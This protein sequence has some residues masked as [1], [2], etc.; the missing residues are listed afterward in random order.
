MKS[1]LGIDIGSVTISLV[2]VDSDKKILQSAYISHEGRLEEKLKNIL[3]LLDLSDIYGIAKTSSTPAIFK[4]TSSYD[5]RVCYITATKEINPE[6]GSLLIVGGEKFGLVLFDE[7]KEY[8]KYKS[9]SSCA[10]GTGSFL[11]QQAKRL[12]IETIEKFSTL[13]YQNHGAFPKIASRCAVFAKTDL[14]HAQ[15]EGYSLQEICDGLCFG[16]AK[17]IVD[18]LF[19]NL[20]CPEPLFFAGGVSQNQAVKKHIQNLIGIDVIT[21]EYGHLYG[22]IGAAFNLINENK[23]SEIIDFSN[24]DN[25]F[26][27][28]EKVKKYYY[29][30]LTLKLSKYPDFDSFKSYEFSSPVFE[31]LTPV[32]VDIYHEIN[33]KEYTIYLGID[34][35]STSTKAVII[36]NSKNV[37]AGFYTRTSG[38]PITAVQNIFSAI[39]DIIKKYD[40][41]FE[42]KGV[43]TTGSGRKFIGKIIGADIVLDEITAHARA[44]YE[45]DKDVDTIIE[46]GG[47]DAKFTTLSNGMVTFSIMNN[48]CAAGTGSFIEE[49]AKKLGVTLTEYSARAEKPSAPMASDRCTVFMERDLNHYLNDGYVVDEILASVLHSV[50][51]NYLTKV[52]IE[53]NIGNKIFFQG[54][55]A[56]N[57]ALVAAFEQRLNK[58]I[59]VSKYCHLTGALGVALDLFDKKHS[60]SKF[61][62]IDLFKIE[63]PIR[64]EICDICTNHCKLKIATINEITEAYGFLCGRDY[65][66]EKFVDNAQSNFNLVKEYN[67]VFRYKPKS[68]E[69]GNITIGIPSGLYL[70]DDI[71]LWRRFFEIL[72]FKTI[73]TEKF[74]NAVKEGKIIEGA[75]FCSPMAAIHG[76]VKYLIDKVDFVFLPTYL[77]DKQKNKEKRRQYCYYSQYIP[78]IISSIEEIEKKNKLINPLLY[79]V[80]SEFLMKIELFNSLKTAGLNGFNLVD[81]SNAYDTAKKEKSERKKK[82]KK[83]FAEVSES[84]ENKNNFKVILLGRPYT[85]LSSSMNN[86]IPEIFANHETLAFFQDQI[87]V[88]E[89]EVDSLQEILTSVKWKYAATILATADKIARTKDLYPVFI[90]SFKCTPDAFVIEYF[91]MIMAQ[92]KKPYLILQL[93]EHD[94]SVGYETRIEAAIRSFKNHYNKVDLAGI[95]KIEYTSS[96][97]ISN[98]NDLKG[99]T[100][101]LP[102]WDE[103]TSRLLEASLK[104]IGIDVRMIQ[105]TTDSIQR[106]VSSNTGQCL[107]LNIIIQDAI[108]YVEEHKLN[109]ENTVVWMLQSSVSCNLGMFMNFMSKTL[110]SY[111]ND[112]SKIRMYKG[113]LSFLD[114]SFNT[115]VNTYLSYM[116][117]G[118][119]RKIQCKIRPYEKQKGQ[120]DLIVKKSLDLLYDTFLTGG[121]KEIALQ[122]VISWFKEIEIEKTNRPKVAVFGDLYA[123]DND[124]FN[125]NL[126]KFIEDNGGEVITTPYSEY[127]KLILLPYNKRLIIEGAYATAAT[128]RFLMSLAPM[129]EGKYSKY[130]YEILNEE[131]MK[132]DKNFEDK[133]KLFNVKSAHNGESMDSILK[134][135]HLAQKHDDLALFV[136]TNPSYCCP[137]LVTEAMTTKLE[138]ITGIPIVTIEYDGTNSSKND[139]IIPFLKY[140]RKKNE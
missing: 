95:S 126:V 69:F 138:K 47:Q 56:K 27:N 129:V 1:Y 37:L 30:N 24:L 121:S 31:K 58:P 74:R 99:K 82:W 21:N 36:D 100:L 136:Q 108:D 70:F 7:D 9:N 48:V 33:K 38:Q 44:A 72:K 119:I 135:L 8:R 91:K 63:I 45:I 132:I 98:P 16:L 10:A 75:E 137:S 25:H 133:L 107:P 15:Q 42:I 77:E 55:T 96:N 118:Y 57:K 124:V 66:T 79:S 140:A 120:T 87:E 46:I 78:P 53:S 28:H 106:S 43:S 4:N 111:N 104:N 14:I 62:G 68:E 12:N 127:M 134:I 130:F 39:D 35:G 88:N 34:I 18:T 103:Y 32:E 11:D 113:N 125:Q 84:P 83:L 49:Q 139:D 26:E 29:P 41:T 71:I 128:R 93:D 54:A 51:E 59:M 123:R 102:T 117:G 115:A 2:K 52:A 112:Y 61:K 80:Q 19:T 13:A 109:P 17:N 110:K 20:K 105:D 94:S 5:N 97:M 73:T 89:S 92:H 81:I 90:T 122:Q 6:I 76:Q 64:T 65:E 40:I 101:L 3:N 116:F 50:R 131:P 85:I 22:S 114:F 67:K 86:Q 60:N 23:S